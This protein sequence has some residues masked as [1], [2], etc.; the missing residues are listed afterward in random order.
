MYQSNALEVR[1]ALCETNPALRS[2]VQAA[3]YAKG[4]RDLMVCKDGPALADALA[5]EIVDLVVCDVDLPGMDFGAWIQRI[6]QNALGRNPF[7]VI[8][9]TLGDPSLPAVRRAVSAGVDRVLRKP[10]SMDILAEHVDALSHFRK[11]FVAT[12]GYVGPSRRASPRAEDEDEPLVEVPN[13]LR[14]RMIGRCGPAE[15]QRLIDDGVG[16]VQEMKAQNT[17]LAVSRSIGRV[18]AFYEGKGTLDAVRC[19]LDRMV[20]LSHDVVR[21][22]RGGELDH[23]ADLASSLVGL[24]MRISDDPI[25]PHRLHLNL[26]RKLGEVFRRAARSKVQ[27]YA[28]M[29]EIAE[30][31]GRAV[32]VPPSG[33]VLH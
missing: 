27:S 4:M 23:L 10:V 2:G 18:L 32:D 7:A 24:V 17:P 29:H 6:R 3:L 5:K 31:V 22:H 8:I 12:D 21:R 25:R 20:A 14:S 9:A 1:A 15:L 26:L 28:V 13:T 30:T 33:G 19:D 16:R 11:P